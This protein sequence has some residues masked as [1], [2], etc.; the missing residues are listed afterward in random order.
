MNSNNLSSHGTNLSIEKIHAYRRL[1][2]T[3]AASIRDLVLQR[4]DF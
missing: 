3:R 2:Q 1:Y 4:D